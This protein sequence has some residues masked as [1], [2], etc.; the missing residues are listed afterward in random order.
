MSFTPFQKLIAQL[1]LEA[2]SDLGFALGGG[3]AL[4][5]HGDAV[6]TR[7]NGP[8]VAGQSDRAA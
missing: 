3:Q 5:A 6:L 7:V 8:A 2:I 4:H 1:I